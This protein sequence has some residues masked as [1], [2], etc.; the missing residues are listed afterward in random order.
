MI[1][2]RIDLAELSLAELQRL[3]APAL[4]GNEKVARRISPALS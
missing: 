2:P 1:T 3:L 4:S